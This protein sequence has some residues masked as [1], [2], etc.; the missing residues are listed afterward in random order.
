MGTDRLSVSPAVE[1][2]PQGAWVDYANS[3][4]VESYA[5]L[6][7][8]AQAQVRDGVTLFVD[9][10]NLTKER[11]IGD[12][13]ALVRYVADDPATPANEGSAAF[14]PIE[15]RAFYAGVRARF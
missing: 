11:A 15:R 13:S 3:K 12:I 7:L 4:R 2:L 6:N 10:R 5:M 8:T 1:W 14:Y 9:A